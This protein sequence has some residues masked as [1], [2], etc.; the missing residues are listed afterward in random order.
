M[1]HKI[2]IKNDSAETPEDGAPQQVEVQDGIIVDVKPGDDVLLV[3][4][5]GVP[6]EVELEREGDDLVVTYEDGSQAKLEDFYANAGTAEPIEITLRPTSALDSSVVSDVSGTLGNVP[7]G[8]DFSLM[9]L[10]NTGYV[11]FAQSIDSLYDQFGLRAP[12][13]DASG[14]LTGGNQTPAAEEIVETPAPAAADDPA[15]SAP[16]PVVE[17]AAKKGPLVA[18]GPPTVRGKIGPEDDP[19]ASNRSVSEGAETAD[20]RVR[21]LSS[22]EEGAGRETILSEFGS[23]SIRE[24]GSFAYIYGSADPGTNDI[25]VI[26]YPVDDPDNPGSTITVSE[27]VVFTYPE[28]GPPEWVAPTA[29][30]APEVDFFTDPDNPDPVAGT[31]V[32]DSV[33]NAGNEGASGGVGD[34]IEGD[35]GILVFSEDGTYDYVMHFDNPLADGETETFTATYTDENGKTSV[36]TLTLVGGPVI[37]PETGEPL[38]D[39]DT[40]ELISGAS[41]VDP[42]SAR[43][44]DP[45][46]PDGSDPVIDPSATQADIT[47]TSL[48]TA[49]TDIAGVF[50][51]GELGT[52][53]V[54]EDGS[55]D[56]NLTPGAA[57][58]RDVFTVEYPNADG[59]TVTETLVFENDGAGVVTII[60]PT[61]SNPAGGTFFDDPDNVTV[62]PAAAGSIVVAS[63]DNAGN[64]GSTGGPGDVVTGDNG[65][66]VF[67]T[68]GTFDYRMD[69]ADPLA[70]GETETFTVSYTDEDGK[71]TV[72]TIVFEGD[73][74]GG[75]AVKPP[76]SGEIGGADDP[77]PSDPA[78]DPGAVKGDIT[79]TSLG[80]GDSDTAGEL[81]DGGKGTLVFNEDGTFDFNVAEGATPGTDVYTVEYP[82]AGGGEPVTEIL[83]FDV[84]P[85]GTA[86]WVAPTVSNPDGESFFTDPDNETPEPASLA[87]IVVESVDNAGNP[88]SSG[89]VGDVVEG[90]NGRLIFNSDGSYD[91]LMDPANPLGEAETETY[92]VRYTDENGKETTETIVFEGDGAGGAA[93][94]PPL[95]SFI[96][97][98][99]DPDASDP[100]IDPSA[101][102]GDI[103]VTSLDTGDT[104][105]AGELVD[106]SKG[107]LVFNEDG[108]FDFNVADGATPGTDVYTVEYP[109][110][111][112]GEPV[113]ETLIFEVK[114]DGT[115][116]WL[117]PTVSNPDGEDFFSDPDNETPDPASLASIVVESVDNSGNPNSTGGVGD[118]VDGENGKLV[119]NSDGSYDYVMDP[120]KPLGEAETETY[121][122]RYT[123]ENGKETTETIV[124]EGDG[125]GGAAVKPPFSSSIGSPEDPDASDP[126]IDPAAVKG[127]ITVTSLD[128]GD[129]DS[130]GE[131]VDGSKGTLVFNED[132]SFDFNV[133]E[134]A[135]PGLD[136]YTVEFP[137][138]G[139]TDPVTETLIFEVK[140]DGTVDWLAPTV[141]N[142]D[143]EDFFSDPDNENPD[144][145]LVS[146]IVV[147]SVDNAGNAGSTG[148]VGDVIRGDNGRLIFNADG[149]YDYLMDADNAL[150][151]GELETYTVTYTDENGEST[152]E[153]IVFEGDGAGGAAVKPPLSLEIGSPDDPDASDH[154]VDPAAAPADITVTSLDTG[155]TDSAGELVD[156]SKGALVF[157]E[158][159]TFDYNVAEDAP[160][161]LDTYTV[162]YPPADGGDPVTEVLVFEVKADGTADL[163]PPTVSNAADESFFDDPD[164]EA[165]ATPAVAGSI[166]VASVD[167]A[168]APN[169]TGVANEPVYGDNGILVF[170]TDGTFDYA[171]DP[172]A[173]LGGGETETFTVT[174][175][176]ENGAETMETLVFEGDGAG[177]AAV[178]PPLSAEIG[179]PD[180]PDASDVVIEPGTARG[181]ITVTS[182]DTTDNGIAGVL[183]DGSRGSLVFNADGT[184]DYNVADGAPVGLDTYTVEY[185]ADGV[186]EP[187]TETLI[188]EVKADGTAEWI[189]P[190]VSNGPGESFF[191]DPDNN[192]PDTATIVVASVDNAG[193]PNSSGGTGAPISGDNGVLVFNPDGTYDYAMDSGNP[194]GDGETETYTVTYTDAGGKETVETLVI[195]GDGADGASVL[196][197][198]SD[199]IMTADTPGNPAPDADTEPGDLT[200]TS[201]NEGNTGAGGEL[202]DGELG[203]LVFNPDGTFDYNP[204]PD[205]PAGTDVY[206][207]SYPIPDPANPG[208][209]MEVSET[210][211]FV[212]DGD[213]NVTVKDPTSGVIGAAGDPDAT[214]PG[215][216]PG[217]DPGDVIVKHPAAG[218]GNSTTAG[219][220]LDGNFGTVVVNPDGT[221][222]YVPEEDHPAGSEDTFTVTYP[223]A[224]AGGPPITETLTFVHDGSGAAPAVAPDTVGDLYVPRIINVTLTDAD[225]YDGDVGITTM[226]VV[227]A[228]PLGAVAAEDSGEVISGDLSPLVSDPDAGDTHTFAS[229]DT[230]SHGTFNLDSSG[231]WTYDLDDSS[232]AINQLNAGDTLTETFSVTVTDANGLSNTEDLTV[233]IYG[234]NDAPHVAAPLVD[235]SLSAPPLPPGP[236]VPAAEVV[237]AIQVG[238]EA[239]FRG[240]FV[241]AGI[242]ANGAFGANGAPPAGFHS[243]RIPGRF[244]FISN[245]DDNNWATYDGDFF[246]P[247]TPAEG[248]GIDFN[249]VASTNNGTGATGIAGSVT[250]VS[251]VVEGRARVRSD[252]LERHSKCGWRDDSNRPHLL[253]RRE[254]SLHPDGHHA[255]QHFRRR[256]QQRVL[257]AHGR[258]GQ[259]PIDQWLFRYDEHSGCE[260]GWGQRSGDR[261]SFSN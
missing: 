133:T 183:V 66:I 235:V 224:A 10:S 255:D 38:V 37:D 102:K 89:G 261:H 54:N 22:G 57:T 170:N 129:T 17:A 77:D 74:A 193:A 136:I 181:D 188:F 145:A 100:L 63:V 228:G 158:D 143:G 219:N 95:S 121:T 260:A 87:S 249:G 47:V 125:D 156:G 86:E 250:G 161:G 98:P 28:V 226:H 241:E 139:V 70:T 119:F 258:S 32:I 81:V 237:E 197:P 104:D 172:G 160:A 59:T 69:S 64:P 192:T 209:T 233:T 174:Y 111:G 223:S 222:D 115:A 244:G 138:D 164:N 225:G 112:G 56:Y 82:P 254:R 49:D 24:D 123:D 238:G 230:A 50:V 73:G 53:L 248:F 52:I 167:N 217:S 35:N 242:R 105:S 194:L 232:S 65:F 247:G 169:S 40:G 165:P 214:N 187:V 198:Y 46:D 243:S 210:L 208:D 140:S 245:S 83:I 6:S 189:A 207:V 177:G 171:M 152:M 44:G 220:P 202:V 79:V 30:N 205:A 168:G 110:V 94:K 3:D 236:S 253:R 195:V 221:F 175:T 91:Y 239:F 185:P 5:D 128:T 85:D 108:T 154:K 240:S 150:E 178:K 96:G 72:E 180:D 234:A 36:E 229:T 78:I 8:D 60:P 92:T 166:L 114:P 246:T 43:F 26:D 103:T 80:T 231:S 130:A 27:T 9:R 25:F 179:G 162:E 101:V 93:V 99:D 7:Q 191:D 218:G 213:G 39:E 34:V 199:D 48:N 15:P 117:A 118:V 62:D 21:S 2:I 76:L 97:A 142:P 127:D 144:P 75:A 51:D 157:N 201:L 206:V 12:T 184:F 211:T 20:I 29:T 153:T 41:V 203:N 135:A 13:G 16:L 23:F 109:P 173:P 148:G 113:T 163:L 132:G 176:D 256:C 196:P 147:D 182:L 159:G 122:V 61:V 55:F 190:A 45:S 120:A 151:N 11:D 88:D 186:A 19:D 251:T 1:K 68:D 124:F 216:Q 90:D 204:T 58:G 259:Q 14:N 141:S 215:V 200:V 71:E 227:D 212:N 137:A 116:E 257:D 131:L 107:T 4:E 67:N 84:K 155:D 126:T 31:I 252:L 42:T 146:S 18:D 106:G 149:S 33:D 134:G